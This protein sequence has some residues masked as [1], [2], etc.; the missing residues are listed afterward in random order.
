MKIF[1]FILLLISCSAFSSEEVLYCN[2][3]EAVGFQP[4][5]NFKTVTFT[6][7]R[8][9]MMVDFEK[10]TIHAPSI[11]W[12]KDNLTGK[13]AN[14]SLQMTCFNSL[15]STFR[16]IKSNLKFIRTYILTPDSVYIAHGQCEKF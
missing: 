13:C 15:K 7:K 14:N 1:T 4:R 9:T 3:I 8:F 11:L 16:L 10:Q 2:D 5:E 12:Y 6:P